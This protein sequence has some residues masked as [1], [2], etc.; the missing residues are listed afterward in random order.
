MV[1]NAAARAVLGRTTSLF[2]QDLAAA[3]DQLDFLTGARVLVAGGSSSVGQQLLVEMLARRPARLVLADS[4]ENGLART[5]RMIRSGDLASPTTDIEP[6]VVD[7]TGPLLPRL[8]QQCGPFDLVVQL[9]ALKHVRSERDDLS[10]ARMFAV[11]TAMPVKLAAAACAQNPEVRVFAVSTDKA[12]APASIMGASKR[13]MEILL[14]GEHPTATFARFANVAFSAGSLLDSWW[15]RIAAGQPLPV[16]IDTQRFFITPTEAAHLCLLALAAPAGS[17][18]VPDERSLTPIPLET[19]AERFLA[20]VGQPNHPML[21]TPLDTSGDKPVEVLVG[22]DEQ[23]RPWLPQVGLVSAAGRTEAA[24]TVVS[25]VARR[26][27]EPNAPILGDEL[28][29]LIRQAVPTYQHI[30]GADLSG[31]V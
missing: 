4:N 17:V 5:I 28:D 2:A 8:L 25:W 19:V 6:V 31:R 14:V 22:P 15:D 21:R 7:L 1:V 13:L 18:A 10:V 20:H 24:A 26:A 9:A 11:N 27:A 30:T 23:P 29:T 12:A 16:P 3:K